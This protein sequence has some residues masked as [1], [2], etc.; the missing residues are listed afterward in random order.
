V[1][2]VP[3]AQERAAVG[4]RHIA[5][6]FREGCAHL[7]PA[8]TAL[9]E[10]E[11]A[12][13]RTG[14]TGDLEVTLMGLSLALR[15]RRDPEDGQ[16]AVVLAQELVN[17]VRRRRGDA[18]ALPFRSYLEGAYKDL[19][20]LETAD[21]AARTAS[22]GIEACDRTLRVAREE[23]SPQVVPS[24]QATK[25]ALLLR[26][27]ALEP[28]ERTPRGG[29]AGALRREAAKLYTAA[30]RDWPAHD[31]AGRAVIQLEMAEMYAA[32]PESQERAL[33]LLDEASATLTRIDNRY[34]AAR[35][36][37]IRAQIAVARGGPDALDALEGAAAAFRAL[38][39]EQDAREVEALL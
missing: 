38:G 12:Q 39:C 8:I 33:R 18:E 27:A 14:A 16:R 25:A 26:L 11:R 3:T 19:A 31:T 36:A 20:Q 5:A 30:L 9:R 32:A 35:A 2:T 17:A 23:R 15:L 34:Q 21:A 37:R 22:L 1:D 13:R 29:R 6:F 28:H 7:P 24:A 4:W 10:A